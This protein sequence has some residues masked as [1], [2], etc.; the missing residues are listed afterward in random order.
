[1]KQ[2]RTLALG[3][4]I[5]L[6]TGQ[7]LFAAPLKYHSKIMRHNNFVQPIGDDCY[8]IGQDKAAELGGELAKAYAASDENGEPVCKLVILVPGQY[9]SRPKRVQIAVPQSGGDSGGY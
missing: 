4:V 9:G 6:L 1:M 8:S 3:L 7:S 2:N 5:A